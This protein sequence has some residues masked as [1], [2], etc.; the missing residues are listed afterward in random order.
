M[1]FSSAVTHKKNS[2]KIAVLH[3]ERRVIFSFIAYMGR[4]FLRS[5]RIWG[6]LILPSCTDIRASAAERAAVCF[7]EL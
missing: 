4:A 3:L 2:N 1:H 6:R 5:M 7:G